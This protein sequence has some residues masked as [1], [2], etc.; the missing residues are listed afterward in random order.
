MSIV[1]RALL[2]ALVAA[3]FSSSARAADYYVDPVN[4][5]P[6]NDG[7]LNAPWRSLQ[8]V[9]DQ[10]PLQPGDTVWL[11]SG[12]HGSLT[13]RDRRNAAPVAVAAAPDAT[14][15]LDRLEVRDS[16]NWRFSGLAVGGLAQRGRI[17]VVG[18][19]AE[20]IT[21]ESST[22]ASAD[23][24]SGWSAGDWLQRAA[25]GIYVIGRRITL[26]DNLIRNVKH[27]IQ[28]DAADSLVE[29]NVIENFSGDGIRGLGDD[30]VYQFNTIRNCYNVDD[31]HDD[32]FQ[33]WS[34]GPLGIPGTG[35]VVGGVVR[36]NRIVNYE[37]PD[38][39]LRC[40]LQG[41]G[42]FDGMFVDWI[43]ENNVVIVDHWHGITVMGARG[44]SIVNNTVIDPNRSQPGPPWISI[45][46]HK[47]G[48]P[49]V[50]SVIADNLTEPRPRSKDN[51]FGLPMPGVEARGNVTVDDPMR[52]FVDVDRGDL[53]PRTGS[54]AFDAG[55][56]DFVAFTDIDATPRPQGPAVDVGVYEAR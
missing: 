26:R 53:R 16:T 35:E 11:V 50:A 38:Q 19:G 25:D 47:D 17:V 5:A 12:E 45:T 21:V 46:H 29:H 24:V 6:A 41:I 37:D 39:P 55:A 13:I 15:H 3:G 49:P 1:G 42:M 27:G 23:D 4:G 34:V 9:I 20:D 18:P 2:V 44:V 10:Q 30:T 33:S 56:P 51:Q 52:F 54:P 22:V 36:G 8:T 14:P 7:S 48:R 32:G 40:T 28:I 43:V 31:N